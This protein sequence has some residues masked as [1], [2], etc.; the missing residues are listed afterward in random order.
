[1][2]LNVHVKL[3]HCKANSSQT[4]EILVDTKSS[5]TRKE[6]LIDKTVQTQTNDGMS[7][8]YEEYSCF[9]CEKKITSELY[10]LEHRITC[11]GATENPSLFVKHHL[12]DLAK[13]HKTFIQDTPDLL[14]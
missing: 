10:L 3:D 5:Q 13:T 9:Y 2:K 8:E 11:H 1:M 14:G 7:K 12:K 4:D 6:T